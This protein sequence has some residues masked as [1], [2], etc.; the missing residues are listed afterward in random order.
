M[1][2]GGD[3]IARDGDRQTNSTWTYQQTMPPLARP[4]ASR[5]AATATQTLVPGVTRFGRKQLSRT[6]SGIDL[7]FTLKN[8][9]F[10]QRAR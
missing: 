9:S 7:T 2:I 8:G 4:K 6:D 5:L 1:V 10:P 3:H